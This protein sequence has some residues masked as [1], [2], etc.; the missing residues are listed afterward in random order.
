[1]TINIK[2]LWRLR[3]NM[4]TKCSTFLFHLIIWPYVT[5]EFP[6][7][8][9]IGTKLTCIIQ[10]YAFFFK[11]LVVINPFCVSDWV[12]D[13]FCTYDPNR[14]YF[15]LQDTNTYRKHKK[16]LSLKNLVYINSIRKVYYYPMVVL[17][18][19]FNE[20]FNEQLISDKSEQ[21]SFLIL[22]GV[23]LSRV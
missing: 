4:T 11:H 20:Y 14:S 10:S 5:D 6:I 19:L 1:M 13:G 15:V 2:A 16:R 8:F 21:A 18:A 22:N 23:L 17:I 7:S 12:K 9:L 3:I